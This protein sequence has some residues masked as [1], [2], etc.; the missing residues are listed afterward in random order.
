[1]VVL[2]GRLVHN[3]AA[4]LCCGGQ[5]FAD[6][7]RLLLYTRVKYQLQKGTLFV[8]CLLLL[9]H[10]AQYTAMLVYGCPLQA[11]LASEDSSTLAPQPLSVRMGS[12]QVRVAGLP[13]ALHEVHEL[14]NGFL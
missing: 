12:L 9:E 5:L 4:W 1:M 3:W 13:P 8:A 11:V 6:Q 7:A 10:P 14:Q 2:L